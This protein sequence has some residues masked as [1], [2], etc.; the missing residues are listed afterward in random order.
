[1]SDTIDFQAITPRICKTVI[2]FIKN[3]YQM[4]SYS[5]HNYSAVGFNS[6]NL[7]SDSSVVLIIEGSVSL[8]THT[9]QSVHH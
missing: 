1:M 4:I 7:F 2:K 9:S 3:T 5:V 8:I 6:Y